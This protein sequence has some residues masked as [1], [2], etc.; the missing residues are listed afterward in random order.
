M[1]PTLR[2][3]LE[4]FE[5]IARKSAESRSAHITEAMFATF[6]S[7]QHFHNAYVQDIIRNMLGMRVGDFLTDRRLSLTPTL[8]RQ[9]LEVFQILPHRNVSGVSRGIIQLIMEIMQER[10]VSS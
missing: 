7:G 6:R 3:S 4:D 8:I 9:T 10:E 5:V 1:L 2:T